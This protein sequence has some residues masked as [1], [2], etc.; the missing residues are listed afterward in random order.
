MVLTGYLHHRPCYFVKP[1]LWSLVQFHGLAGDLN[2]EGQV[3]CNEWKSI[4]VDRNDLPNDHLNCVLTGI[5]DP[6]LHLRSY[7]E[8]SFINFQQITP[9][10]VLYRNI[11]FQQ[12]VNNLL[13]VHVINAIWFLYVFKYIGKIGTVLVS[14][15][16][17]RNC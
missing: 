12:P 4:W 6:I 14:P 13:F 3:K 16:I 9:N 15:G 2:C 1:V 10:L 17:T 11:T 5:S 8:V 7:P